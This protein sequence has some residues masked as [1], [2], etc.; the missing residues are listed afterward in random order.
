MLYDLVIR[1]GTVVDGSG[2][3]RYRADVAVAGNRIAEIG[4]VTERGVDEFD[5]EGLFV[6][7]GFVD[8][9]THLDAQICWDPFGPAASHGVTSVVMGNCG[10]GVAPCRDERDR[11]NFIMPALE[12]AEDIHRPTIEAG[13]S[14]EWESFADYMEVIARLPKGVNFGANV[15]HGTLRSYVMG[16]RAYERNEATEDD[17]SAM[18]RELETAIAAG[19]LGFTSMLPGASLFIYYGDVDP[20]EQDPRIV[21]GLATPQ[22]VDAITHV[23]S[24]RS[25]GAIQLGGSYW[26]DAVRLSARTGLPVQFVYGNGA[27]SPDLTLRHFDAAAAQ[28]ARMIPSVSGRPQ[29][30]VIGFRARLPFDGLPL[31]K[32]LRARPLAEQRA[33]LVDPLRRAQLVDAAR[34]SQYPPVHGL[35]ARQPEWDKLAIVDRPL[36]PFV[37]VGERASELG[38]DPYRV[39][40]DLCLESD[41][42]QLFS[43]PVTW[44]HPRETWLELLR[45]P[46]SVISQADTGAHTAQAADWVMPTWFLGYWVRQEQEF[47]WEQGVRMFTSDPAA[48]WGGLDGRGVLRQGAPADLNV[49]D[50]ETISPAVPD[51]DDCLPGGGKRL[52]CEVIGMHATVVGG[53]ITF[54][55]GECTGALPGTVLKP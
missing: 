49:F 34:N 43:Q 20:H 39:F 46:R 31:W 38:Q 7:P 55:D 42:H 52:T 14:W 24:K 3:Q 28:G 5:A 16:E 25:R 41:F 36:G 30:S 26:N 18:C 19:A 22:E 13:V 50:P 21:C 12:V 6:T 48:V 10:I 17:I 15:A 2:D 40:L 45:H 35:A 37:T 53:E 11:E 29:T 9:H 44:D 4:R 32:E 27:P 1:N 33:A 54:R 8:N 23:L 51:A 47:T